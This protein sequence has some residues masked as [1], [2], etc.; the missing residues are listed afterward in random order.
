MRWT[1]L[2]VALLGF[3]GLWGVGP[4]YGLLAAFVV[5][6]VNFASFCLLYDRPLERARQRVDQQR[7][8]LHPNTDLAQRLETARVVP[9][10][11]D[12]HLGLGPMTALNY[13][14]GI[15]AGGFVVWAFVLRVF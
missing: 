5:L 13:V 12:R 9:T 2:G 6:V 1:L 11:A 10:A 3:F 15:A 7:R 8:K 14:S 4:G